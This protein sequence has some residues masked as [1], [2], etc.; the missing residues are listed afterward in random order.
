MAIGNDPPKA[1][2]RRKSTA[3][4]S[5]TGGGSAASTTPPPTSTAAPGTTQAP[6]KPNEPKTAVVVIHGMGEPTPLQTITAFVDT[7]YCQDESLAKPTAKRP[8]N[9]SIAPD[10]ATGS[11]ELRRI[12]TH[13]SDGPDKRTDFYEFYWADIMDGTPVEMVTSWIQA[14]LLR[15]PWRV[16]GSV[17]VFTAWLILWA[18][19]LITVTAGLLTLYPDLDGVPFVT[20]A[21][22]WF[23][24]IRQ[25]AGMVLGALGGLALLLGLVAA[26]RAG[27]IRKLRLGAP[28]FF[29]L[30][31]AVLHFLPDDMAKEPRIW[32]AAITAVVA[33]FMNFLVAPYLGDVVRYVRAT[34]S[35]V[36]RRRLVRERGLA[37]LEAIHAKRLDG[38]DMWRHTGATGAE[39]PYYDR[40]VIVGHSLGS[41]V[42]Y[43]LLQLF[44]ERHGPTHHQDWPA[45]GET[46]QT[47]LADV[48]TFVNGQWGDEPYT[49]FPR[50]EFFDAQRRLQ[51]VLRDESPHWRITDLITLGSPLS[52]AE[53]LLADSVEEMRHAFLDR[54]FATSPPHPDRARGATMLYPGKGGKTLYPHFAAQFA[55]VK[56]TNIHDHSHLPLFGDLISGAL[57][58]LFGPGVEDHNVTIK[59]GGWPWLIRRIFTHTQY[60]SW[61][62]KYVATDEQRKEAVS[63]D[64]DPKER[65]TILWRNVPD[66]IRKLRLALRLGE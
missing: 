46:I 21:V 19:A 28:L 9:I 62:D 60:W 38:E 56:W 34:P 66:H 35:T 11:S 54:R 61:H 55:T 30:A 6:G 45:A 48:D 2:R 27:T 65:R 49:T 58:W 36:E 31:G 64:A 24:S 3:S 51:K 13:G 59:R 50:E 53:F 57:G 43:D 12:T 39:K 1:G 7:V 23:A 14:L 52:H 41:I 63:P 44:W 16:P 42:A 22:M 10:S 47:A 25:Q 29:G 32:A 17:R 15:A 8:L 20:E 33:W 26:I 4:S 18:L 40:I 37:L 5:D